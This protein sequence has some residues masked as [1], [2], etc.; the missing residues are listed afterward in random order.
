MNCNPSSREVILEDGIY[1]FWFQHSKEVRTL[2][3]PAERGMLP[4]LRSAPYPALCPCEPLGPVNLLYSSTRDTCEARLTSSQLACWRTVSLGTYWYCCSGVLVYTY[5]SVVV[6]FSFCF[7]HRDA[8]CRSLSCFIGH[9]G[10][11]FR[12]RAS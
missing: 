8:Y 6:L 2:T 10:L 4:W 1:P 5:S 3:L 7:C 9:H 12:T 11:D